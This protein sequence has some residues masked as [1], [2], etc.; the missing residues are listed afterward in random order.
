MLKTKHIASLFKRTLDGNL[1]LTNLS[2]KIVDRVVSISQEV[3][4]IRKRNKPSI[5][6][7]ED[8]LSPTNE[9]QVHTQSFWIL[10]QLYSYTTI[11]GKSEI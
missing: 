3:G 2:K 9:D 6:I 1:R 7:E 4:M 8:T 10:F 5:S 11:A